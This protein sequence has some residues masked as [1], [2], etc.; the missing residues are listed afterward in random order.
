ME[1]IRFATTS[2]LRLIELVRWPAAVFLL[3]WWFRSE[4]RS[5]VQEL[6]RRLDTGT[7]TLQTPFGSAK[8][9]CSRSPFE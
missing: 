7:G 5:G 1:Y 8:R 9:S 4:I 3:A 6:F 2:V